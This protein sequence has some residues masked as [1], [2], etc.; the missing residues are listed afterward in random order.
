[1]PEKLI[2][3]YRM[4]TC[5]PCNAM[6][7]EWN[8][9][10]TI[11][12]DKKMDDENIKFAEYEVN[13]DE[14][15]DKSSNV[16]KSDEELLLEEKRSIN[17]FPTIRM[18]ITDRKTK[19]FKGERTTDAFLKFLESDGKIGGGDTDVENSYEEYQE[20]GEGNFDQCGGGC[21][22]NKCEFKGGKKVNNEEYYKMKYFKY[23]AKYIELKSRYNLS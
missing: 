12:K 4:S 23:K 21:D 20:E 14:I 15:V 6:K 9:F 5:G 11:F 7:P 19:D 18:F 8:K 13:D 3:L 1:M 16:T 22:G 17:G 2:V 10:K